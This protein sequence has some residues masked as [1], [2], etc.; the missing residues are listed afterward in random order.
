[1]QNTLERRLSQRMGRKQMH[2]GIKW[3]SDSEQ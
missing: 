2:K 3:S 1:M